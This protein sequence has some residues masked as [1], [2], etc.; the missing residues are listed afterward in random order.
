MVFKR[1]VT[2][3]DWVELDIWHLRGRLHA[4]SG[5]KR[6]VD[7][8]RDHH[9]TPVRLEKLPRIGYRLP[10]VSDVID[11]VQHHLVD[12]RTSQ[13]SAVGRPIVGVDQ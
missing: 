9:P 2:A 6:I 3:V 12:A 10:V 8:G 13:Q 11:E 4:C 7:T 1:E 5:K